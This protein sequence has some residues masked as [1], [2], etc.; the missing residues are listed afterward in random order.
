MKNLGTIDN[1]MMKSSAAPSSSVDNGIMQQKKDII[2]QSNSSILKGYDLAIA[3]LEKHGM[4]DA[5]IALY[6]NRALIE[7]GLNNGI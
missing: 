1:E 6:V 3:L 7:I 4:A 2:E 5:V